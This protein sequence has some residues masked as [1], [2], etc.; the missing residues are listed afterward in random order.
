MKRKQEKQQTYTMTEV[1]RYALSLRAPKDVIATLAD[2]G[3]PVGEKTWQDVII[4]ALIANA[5]KG[6][7]PHTREI[8]NR[9]EGLPQAKISLETTGAIDDE[10]AAKILE[11]AVKQKS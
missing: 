1:L 9:I 11:T 7:L 5:A 3:L 6:S 10:T 4:A 2:K 8:F